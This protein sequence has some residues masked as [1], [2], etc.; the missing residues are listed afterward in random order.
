MSIDDGN[1]TNGAGAVLP[2]AITVPTGRARAVGRTR[3]RAT[4]VPHRAAREGSLQGSA[5]GTMF[6]G[7]VPSVGITMEKLLENERP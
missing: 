6:E 4:A 5:H 1:Q 2:S 7:K 3:L